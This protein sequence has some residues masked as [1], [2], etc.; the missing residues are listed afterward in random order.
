M[1]CTH[2]GEH[3]ALYGPY[4]HSCREL[5]IRR[6]DCHYRKG[7]RLHPIVFEMDRFLSPSDREE[8]VRKTRR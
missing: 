2:C 1:K 7:K 5:L 6:T 4:C 8:V 3:M